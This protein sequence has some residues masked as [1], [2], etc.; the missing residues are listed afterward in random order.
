MQERKG[1]ELRTDRATTLGTD[2]CNI[3]E[4]HDVDVEKGTG[5]ESKTL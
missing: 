5:S 1:P 3:R 2:D 4:F